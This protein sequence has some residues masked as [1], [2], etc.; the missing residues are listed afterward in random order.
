MIINNKAIEEKFLSNPRI[1]ENY[2]F[3]QEIGV[4]SFIDSIAREVYN[5]KTLL[6]KGLDIFN[7]TNIIDIMDSTV[8]QLS[9]HF[10]PSFIAFIW[11]PLQNRPDVTIQAYRN[12]SPFDIDLKIDNI[13]LFEPFF[14]QSS[15]PITFEALSNVLQHHPDLAPYK[16]IQPEIVIPIIGPLGLYGI[17]LVGSKDRNE[18][19]TDEELEFIK[20]LMAFMAQAIKNHLHYEHS[21]RDAKTGLYNHGFFMDR[22]NVEISHTK[23]KRYE[24][25]VIVS[26]VDKFKHFND[27]YGHIAGDQVLEKLAQVIKQSVRDNDVPARFGGEEFTIMLPQTDIT[28]AWIVAERL[29]NNVA[30][31]RVPWE[32]ELPQVTIS[33][34]IFSF[35]NDNKLGATD[36][37]RRADEALYVSKARGRNRSTI[38]EPGLITGISEN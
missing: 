5:Y 33:L 1:L 36:V 15:K 10:L 32:V 37:L 7:Q 38:W 14:Q 16:A 9:Y 26:D 21:L 24:T 31:M 4:F 23:R 3:L 12:Y 22:L 28:I 25:S 34:G 13:T 29:R 17:I 8:Q 6:T 18:E 35:N 27:T 30:E 19:Y 2:S 20:Y 11:K